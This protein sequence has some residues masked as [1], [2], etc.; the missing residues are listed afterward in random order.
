VIR[1]GPPAAVCRVLTYRDGLLSGFG[2]DLVLDVTRFDVRIDEQRRA[3]DASF[4]AA[5]LRVVRALRDGVELEGALGAADRRTI[6]ENV[7]RDVLECMRHPEVR[8]R[9]T[10]VAD[11][12][13]GFDVTGRLALHG[14]EREVRLALRRAGDRYEG[15]VHLHQPDF[16]IRPYS[17][18]LGA[19]GVKPDVVVRISLPAAPASVT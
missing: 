10:R 14:A 17:A 8:F 1:L 13:D 15:E 12:D 3:V 7:R 5:S 16:G 9:S 2:H 11:R 19:L 18:M 6:E 4:D